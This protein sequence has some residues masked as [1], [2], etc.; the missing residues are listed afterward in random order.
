MRSAANP[1]RRIPSWNRLA[2]PRALSCPATRHRNRELRPAT[3]LVKRSPRRLLRSR[4]LPDNESLD[5]HVLGH[6]PERD[7]HRLYFSEH[8][9]ETGVVGAAHDE[10]GAETVVAGERIAAEVDVHVA[11]LDLGERPRDRALAEVDG[12]GTRP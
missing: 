2:R 9:I 5:S 7:D 11:V 8:S 4:G 1:Q 3:R 10:G 6:G 12:D